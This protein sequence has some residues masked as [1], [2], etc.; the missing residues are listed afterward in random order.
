MSQIPYNERQGINLSVGTALAQT[1]TVVFSNSNGVSFGMVSNASGYTITASNSGGGVNILA[2]ISA[3][4][5][6]ATGSQVVLSDSNGLKFGVNG[7]TITAN[8]GA[9]SY[10]DNRESGTSASWSIPGS[11]SALILSLQR[12]AFPLP[13]S[14]TRADLIASMT[15]S[16]STAG[17]IS[18]SIGAYTLSRSTASLAS[19]GSAAITWNSG[20]NSTAA[21]IYGGQ[22]HARYRSVPLG[23]WA[24]TPGDYM[25]G[26]MISISGVAGSTAGVTLYGGSSGASFG[27][28]GGGNLS[29]GFGDG[30]FSVG[31]A[32]LPVSIHVSA[33]NQTRAVSA[34]QPYLQ[35]AGTF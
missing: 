11:S 13:I 20:T 29:S 6:F 19:S 32:A 16:G 24:I 1:G 31:T 18:I 34:G 12:A 22:S 14:A 2:S 3:G 25:I 28:P 8:L 33:I 26:V 30:Q 21:S 35:L 27:F 15:V 9:L 17:S 23:T 5:T 7:Q 10:W 4:T